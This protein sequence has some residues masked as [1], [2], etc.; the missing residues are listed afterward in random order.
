MPKVEDAAN[1]PP[2]ETF[3]P[4][5]T[6]GLIYGFTGNDHRAELEGCMTDLE[7]LATDFI[8]AFDDIKGLHFIHFAQDLGDIIWMLPEAVSS[9]EQLE[10]LNEDI[11]VMLTWAE[12]LKQP[13]QVAKIA[14]K[15]WLFHGVKIKKDIAEGEADYAK[16]DYYGAG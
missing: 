16:S 14:S 9:C 4:D 6:A 7:P 8:S 13:T 1:M 3:V 5:F 15:N 10:Q 2:V 12:Q 11:E